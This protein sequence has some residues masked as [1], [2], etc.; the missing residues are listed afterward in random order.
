LDYGKRSLGTIVSPYC[1]VSLDE[2]G[3][4]RVNFKDQTGYQL[5]NVKCVAYHDVYRKVGEYNNIPV[6]ISLS[7]AWKKPGHNEYYYYIQV[8]GVFP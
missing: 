3:N 6:R 8:S 5:S 1:K 7:R 2:Y 4:A